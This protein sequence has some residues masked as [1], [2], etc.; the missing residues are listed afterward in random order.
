MQDDLSDVRQILV[1]AIKGGDGDA[2]EALVLAHPDL[3]DTPTD[4]GL[5]PAVLAM[6]YGKKRVADLLVRHGAHLDPF[7][8]ATVG[9]PDDMADFLASDPSLA[10]AYSPDGWTLLHLASHFGHR[11][12]V[13]LLLDAG[14]DTAALAHNAQ[15]NTPLQA[16]LAGGQ[17]A[18]AELLL[19]RGA[20]PNGA[21]EDGLT[22]LHLAAM[23][24]DPAMVRL[25]LDRGAAIDVPTKAG[26]TALELATD[27]GNTEAA[28]ILRR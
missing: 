7:G 8:A 15:A 22:P 1:D 25:L 4:D 28:E 9:L 12:I 24:G 2:V 13:E 5:H 20:D 19:D 18:V 26:K 10:R 6:Y 23:I 11:S 14:A 21:R 17:M 16:A 3:V 27:A